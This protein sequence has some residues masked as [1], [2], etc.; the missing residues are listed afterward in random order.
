MKTFFALFF[1][2]I[3]FNANAQSTSPRFGTAAG[4]DN[5]FRVLTNA[6]RTVTDAA[7]ADS[8]SVSPAAFNSIIRVALTDSITFR[9][10]VVTRSFAGDQLTIIATGTSG[11]RVKF[12]GSNWITAGTATLSSGGSA[13]ITLVFNGTRWAERSR[14]VN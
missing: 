7:G 12:T 3:A 9:N 10:P 13:V 14:A 4:Q 8:A 5:T 1:A 6:Y 11:N 2:L